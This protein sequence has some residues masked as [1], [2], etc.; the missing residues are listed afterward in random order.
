MVETRA[1]MVE[2]RDLRTRGR[3]TQDRKMRAPVLLAV[4]SMGDIRFGSRRQR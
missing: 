4:P 2:T 3:Q 1:R